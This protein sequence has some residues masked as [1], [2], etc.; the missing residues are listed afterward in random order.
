MTHKASHS[1]SPV[2]PPDRQEAP[3]TGFQPGQQA[4][5]FT[6]STVARAALNAGLAVLASQQQG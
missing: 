5:K 1:A 2:T 6:R 4:D 3:Q